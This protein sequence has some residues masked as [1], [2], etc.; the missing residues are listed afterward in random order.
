MRV[1]L[2][3]KLLFLVLMPHLAIIG[4]AG[5]AIW[6]QISLQTALEKL[7]PM[8]EIATTASL[9]IHELQKERGQT[10]GL[11]TNQYASD[12]QSRLAKQRGLSDG[13]LARYADLLAG[14]DTA[15]LPARMRAKLE[16]VAGP[17]SKVPEH[18]SVVDRRDMTVPGNVKFYTG[19][20][21]SL[22]DV[23]SLTAEQSPSQEI[24]ALLLPYVSLVEAKEHSGLERAIGA[25][26]LNTTA[27]GNF[28]RGRYEAYL[29]RLNGEALFLKQ[30]QKYA[31][32]D[33]RALFA[34]TVKGPAV[35][36]VVEWRQVL[37]SL[38]DTKDT[39][40][41]TGTEW[42]ATATQ[43]INMFKTVEDAI[44]DE[45][46]TTT[47]ES[48]ASATNTIV[49]LVVVNLL[50]V[51][52]FAT[53]GVSGALP[54]AN[55]IGRF[56]TNIRALAAGETEVRLVQDQK[57]D[58]IG[59]MNRALVQFDANIREAQ[60][61]QD[62]RAQSEL[63]SAEQ[64]TNALKSM[65]DAVE[66][67]LSTTVSSISDEGQAVAERAGDL[68]GI[69][70]EVSTGAQAVAAAAEEA[71]ANASTVASLVE[72]V[73]QALNDVADRVSTARL[74]ADEA[75]Q[76][77][78]ET[79]TVV[80]RLEG[81][82]SEVGAV[83]GLIGDIAEQTNL[84]ALNATIEAARAGD[85][86]K[87]FAVVANEVKSLATQTS[88]SAAEISSQ[89]DLMQSTTADAVSAMAKIGTAVGAIT[90][91]S[92]SIEAAVQEQKSATAEIAN[93]AAQSSEGS[94][95]VSARIAE[96][97][98]SLNQVDQVSQD[99]ASVSQSL[100]ADIDGLQ[101]SIRRIVRTATPEVN[102][103]EGDRRSESQ[104]VA[105]DRRKG[106]D[107]RERGDRSAEM[108]IAAE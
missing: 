8:T 4:L 16:E 34:E 33:Q 41:V 84:L 52:A 71:T 42:F 38:P 2:K 15:I 49:Q 58:D 46:R 74:S 91:A 107:R 17:L 73:N 63:E 59:D 27:Q 14:V 108:A 79:G 30:F 10:V 87:G 47:A 21:V 23:I 93:N 65:A 53:V 1:S 90:E 11:I 6:E 7:Q 106:E 105:N 69:S 57:Q 37:A 24:T 67:E 36:Q 68:S 72:Q 20:I 28:Q 18:R 61:A 94:K 78:Q 64:K 56:V 3:K 29:F 25:A 31:S 66:G 75:A 99:L 39:L 95:E 76:A 35:E 89:M 50:V 32:A 103:R 26:V 85:A 102:Q 104:P 12:N 22:I 48:I 9:L 83:V 13:A 96:V 44:A 40:G 80:A 81:A 62:A 100:R 51:L 43:R 77:A 19:I 54:I 86:G 97:T 55:R 101:S 45:I 70:A 5:E 92:A 98:D 60:R 88:K 82:A